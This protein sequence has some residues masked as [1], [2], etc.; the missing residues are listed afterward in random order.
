MP[1]PFPS[2]RPL[3]TARHERLVP[4]LLVALGG[5][6]GSN[7]R[8][9]VEL[10]SSTP[11]VST[12]LVNVVGSFALGVVLY[13]GI[14]RGMLSERLQ[15][16]VGTGILA[17]FTTYSTFAYESYAHP[18]L[19]LMYVCATYALGFVGVLAGR[20]VAGRYRTEDG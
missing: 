17:S 10:L 14:Y 8:Y 11:L 12:L 2:T 3:L 5:F 15:L 9:A 6:V 16:V 20:T 4:I 19:A 7:L 13:E 1:R 18:D